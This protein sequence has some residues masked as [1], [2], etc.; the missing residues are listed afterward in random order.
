[1]VADHILKPCG[2][3]RQYFSPASVKAGFDDLTSIIYQRYGKLGSDSDESLVVKRA[4]PLPYSSLEKPLP[5]G[6]LDFFL[7]GAAM[8]LIDK[9]SYVRCGLS[10]PLDK[11][12][13]KARLPLRSH[14]AAGEGLSTS[15]EAS[16]NMTR[17]GYMSVR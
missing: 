7:I 1:M 2:T 16:A 10:I 13:L 3:A 4:V 17:G 6:W 14:S 11:K 8:E 9:P 12:E 15:P 5:Q